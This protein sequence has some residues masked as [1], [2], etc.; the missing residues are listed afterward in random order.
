MQKNVT[1]FILDPAPNEAERFGTALESAAPANVEI[2]S[3]G[4]TTVEALNAALQERSA[5]CI[6]L[7][8][9]SG[10]GEEQSLLNRFARQGSGPATIV[11]ADDVPLDRAL[12]W[13]HRGI[14]DVLHRDLPAAEQVRCIMMGLERK[15]LL[16]DAQEAL[17][18]E[19]ENV[20]KMQNFVDELVGFATRTATLGR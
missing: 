19:Q 10:D 5:D 7:Q 14:Q 6:F 20:L 13:V 3:R 9:R 12:E 18:L 1:V 15:R 17:R 16:N 2:R 8:L 11:M 4:F